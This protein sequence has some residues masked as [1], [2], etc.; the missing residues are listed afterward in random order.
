MQNF[1]KSKMFKML[2][3][4]TAFLFGVMVFSIKTKQQFFIEKILAFTIK[5]FSKTVSNFHKGVVGFFD[6]FVKV[7]QF[8]EENELLKKEIAKTRKKVIE[9]NTLKNEN[10]Q[11]KEALKIQNSNKNFK[12]EIASFVARNPN[13]FYGFTINIGKNKNIAEGDVVLTKNGFVG[14]IVKSYGTYSN[15]STIL[16]LDVQVP[17]IDSERDEKG[18]LSASAEYSKNGLCLIKHLNK[19]T[20]CKVGDIISTFSNSNFPQNIPIGKIKELHYGKNGM[21][22]VAVVEPFENVMA[23]KDVVVIKKPR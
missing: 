23:V 17:V 10:E 9:F 16:G 1:F 18:I 22:S 19:S 5:P 4:L 7:G 3:T 8:K 21:S 15:V 12:I 14:I 20:S 6:E 2:F 11:L 13:D